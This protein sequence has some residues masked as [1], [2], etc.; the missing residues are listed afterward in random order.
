MPVCRQV[1]ENNVIPAQAGI[2][3]KDVSLVSLDPRLREGDGK[4]ELVDGLLFT[5]DIGHGGQMLHGNNLRPFFR[6]RPNTQWT[7]TL[8]LLQ[9]PKPSLLRP[10]V[11]C[12]SRDFLSTD[13]GNARNVVSL[14][15]DSRIKYQKLCRLACRKHGNV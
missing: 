3:T 15:I 7:T 11:L 9:P 13:Q 2:Q 8:P 4:A 6:Q 12:L 1:C 5:Q 10:N 14:L